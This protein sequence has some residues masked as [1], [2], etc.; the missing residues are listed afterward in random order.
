MA[1]IRGTKGA[2]AHLNGTSGDDVILALGGKDTIDGGEGSDVIVAG[3]GGNDTID[4]GV[5]SAHDDVDTLVL[6]GDYGDYSAAFDQFN[7]IVLT[8]DTGTVETITHIE[9]IGFD[10]QSVLIVGAGSNYATIQSAIDAAQ[11]GDIIFV[12][13]GTYQEQLHV[14]GKSNLTIMG[15]N[16]DQVTIQAPDDVVQTATAS[17]GAGVDAVVTVTNSSNVIFRNIDVDGHGRGDT[18]T[19]GDD[20]TGVIYRNSSGSLFD[21]DITGCARRAAQRRSARRR[22]AG[23]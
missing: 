15:L 3:N 21:V 23:G 11:D 18:V 8:R 5:D 13:G 19:G 20:F 9:T 7:H 2:D 16:G 17:N 1:N 12:A 4:G 22:P 14:D 10:D 6:S